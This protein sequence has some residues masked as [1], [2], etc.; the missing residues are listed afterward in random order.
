MN[1]LQ[2]IRYKLRA[3][4]K[5]WFE[6]P[7]ARMLCRIGIPASAITVSGLVFAGVAAYFA[8]LGI[9]WAAGIIAAF[10][11]VY[12][13]LD[14]AVARMSGSVSKKG[15]LLD[16]V[17]D[18]IQEGVILIGLLLYYDLQDPQPIGTILVFIAFF[19]SVM[20]SYVRAR[21]EGLGVSDTTAGL[22]TR[23]ERAVIM[24][25]ALITG[26]PIVGL[27]ILAIGTPISAIW[28]LWA[29]WKAA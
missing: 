19:G 18:R 7:T 22:L 14:G 29:A 1:N 3:V 26:Y 4:V 23:P 16:S 5:T 6:E 8:Y 27:W 24:V 10:S 28:R 13:L 17:I 20:V 21:A 2:S 15:A 11:S 12:D 25:V 9:F